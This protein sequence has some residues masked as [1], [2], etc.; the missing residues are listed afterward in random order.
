MFVKGMSAGLY[1]LLYDILHYLKQKPREKLFL[2]QCLT[3]AGT[4]LVDLI[5]V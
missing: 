4:P 5:L 3:L 2:R 1:I